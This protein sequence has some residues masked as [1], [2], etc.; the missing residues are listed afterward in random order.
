MTQGTV[1]SSDVIAMLRRHYLPENRPPGGVFAPEIGS[2]CGRRRA[3]LIWLSTT[4]TG[5]RHMIGHEVKVSR[6]DVLVELADPTKAE[7]WMQYCDQWYLVVSD[8]ALVDGLEIPDP[9]GI[10]APPSGRRTRSMTVVR[11]APTLAPLAKADGVHRVTSWLNAKHA[12][13][14]YALD[15]EV[16]WRDRTI[17]RQNEQIREL[18]EGGSRQPTPEAKRIRDI[19]AAVGK[20]L[21]DGKHWGAHVTDDDLIQALVDVA[22]LRNSARHVKDAIARIAAGCELIAKEAASLPQIAEVQ[23]DVH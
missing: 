23:H 8:P 11:K 14:E 7:P 2:P 21:R 9:W 6:S 4:S 13:I 19:E 16:N 18:R 12:A 3:D 5:R 1:N 15:R 17:E 10:L 20:A 22:V